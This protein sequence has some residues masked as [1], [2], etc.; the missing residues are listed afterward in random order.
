MELAPNQCL[1]VDI[2][3]GWNFG[4]MKTWRKHNYFE[5]FGF[6]VFRRAERGRRES[7]GISPDAS[8]CI[9]TCSTKPKR[10]LTYLHGLTVNMV[11][12][13]AAPPMQEAETYGLMIF[14]DNPTTDTQGTSDC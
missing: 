8:Q 6:C 5:R 12:A 10:A 9:E 13:Q 3:R 1:A 14:L 7:Y 4:P 2:L 11:G